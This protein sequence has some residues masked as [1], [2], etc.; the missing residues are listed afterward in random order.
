MVHEEPIPYISPDAGE[1]EAIAEVHDP[2]LA[3]EQPADD[4]PAHELGVVDEAPADEHAAAVD[5]NIHEPEAEATDAMIG[6]DEAIPAP[7]VHPGRIEYEDPRAKWEKGAVWLAV[8]LVSLLAVGYGISQLGSVEIEPTRTTE[9]AEVDPNEQQ[10]EAEASQQIA[11]APPDSDVAAVGKKATAAKAASKPQ[12]AASEPV[13]GDAVDSLAPRTRAQ[14][15]PVADAS[16]PVREPARSSGAVGR[17]PVQQARRNDAGVAP[18]SSIED[19]FTGMTPDEV[20]REARRRWEMQRDMNDE[21]WRRER[22]R[23]RRLSRQ[24]QNAWPF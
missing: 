1:T 7:A 11:D 16:E 3:V 4:A 22:R 12:Q 6:D 17:R 20:R 13:A 23:Q 10:T 14:A 2:T 24:Q 18:A 21:E 15:Q 8:I 19:V 9:A 5:S